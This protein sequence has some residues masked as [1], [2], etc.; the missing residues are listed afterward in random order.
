VDAASGTSGGGREPSRQF[1]YPECADSVAPYKIGGAHRHTP[2]IARNFAAM[3]ALKGRVSPPVVFTPHLVPM[4]RG[5]LSTIYI[6]LAAGYAAEGN[7]DE[8]VSSLRALYAD[9]YKDEPFV[10]VL[11]PGLIAA[12]NR[13]RNSNYCDISVHTDHS[14]STLIVV[15]AIDNMVK[16]A[17]GQA[18][19][20]MNL[21]F[22]FDERTGL[23]AI[24]SVF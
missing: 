24:P 17:A 18:I 10:R 15:S 2:E 7:I 11:P 5:I 12:A 1:H 4:N 19:Q 9:F 3:A 23:E 13:V 16:G 20:N 8:Q 21:I 22:G 6:P 14:G